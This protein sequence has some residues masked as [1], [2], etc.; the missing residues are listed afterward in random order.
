MPELRSPKLRPV[1]V[2]RSALL[3]QIDAD[4]RRQLDATFDDMDLDNDGH[5]TTGEFTR[6]LS[7]NPRG[8]PLGDLLQGQSEA[9]RAQM[10]EYWFRKIDLTN[11]GYITKAELAAFF[12]AMKQT[13]VREQF[14]ADFLLN[15]FDLD[16]DQRLN[17]VEMKRM[18]RVML[19]HDPSPA[20]VD[21]LCGR[22]G[23]C[24]REEL[25]ALLHEVQCSLGSIE[26]STAATI[27]SS[28]IT[29]F[30][31]FGAVA[32]AVIIGWVYYKKQSKN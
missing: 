6:Y 4:E 28:S 10:I 32:A 29:D 27:G 2:E 30:M 11:E 12:Q 16:M 13:S 7:R 14:L 31:I 26:N 24:S 22:S 25:V 8:W 5:V 23:F 15:L 18:L 1:Q 20:T 19:G 9:V 21:H 3:A 17:K